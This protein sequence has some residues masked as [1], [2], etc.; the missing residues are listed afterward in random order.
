MNFMDYANDTCIVMFTEKQ[1]ERM[2]ATLNGFRSELYNSAAE[3]CS[4]IG[5]NNISIGDNISFYPN[6]SDGNIFINIDL[7]D[8]NFI[9]VTVYNAIGEAVI[10]ETIKILSGREIKLDMNNNPDGIYLIEVKTNKGNMTK[11]IVIN[12]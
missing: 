5:V 6:P 1:K 9:D 2:Y 7:P 12:R 4:A 3:K 11:K 8:I 10:S